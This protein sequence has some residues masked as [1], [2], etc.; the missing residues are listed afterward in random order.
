MAIF[1][2]A[3]SEGLT[4]RV[5]EPPL[6]QAILKWQF[7]TFQAGQWRSFIFPEIFCLPSVI[8]FATLLSDLPALDQSAI[9]RMQENAHGK[10]CQ[11]KCQLSSIPCFCIC[12]IQNL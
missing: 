2:V 6:A 8:S 3:L 5:G 11:P 9:F 10:Q 4:P 1:T 12:T 7:L